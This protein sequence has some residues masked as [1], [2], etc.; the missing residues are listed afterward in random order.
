MK[1][2]DELAFPKLESLRHTSPAVMEAVSTE[3]MALRDYFAAKALQG[4][5]AS[6]GEGENIPNPNLAAGTAYVFADAMLRARAEK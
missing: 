5:L 3:G 4:M 1:R 6:L 2:K